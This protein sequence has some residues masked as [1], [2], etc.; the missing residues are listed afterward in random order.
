MGPEV[1]IAAVS[2]VVAL[3]SV[4][5]TYRTALV[6]HRL[7]DEARNREKVEL[8][9]DLFRRYRVPLLS[10]AESL[11]SRLH[12]VLS[13]D[14]LHAYLHDGDAEDRYYVRHN[15]VY[16][17]AEHLAWLE[18]LRRE[19]RF[20]DL[21]SVKSTKELFAAI[22]R[23]HHPLATDGLP[24][25]FRVFRGHQRAIGEVMLHRVETSDGT[26]TDV[27]GYAAFCHRLET[28][29][30]FA[31]WFNRLL[32]EVDDVEAGGRRGNERLVLLQN[33]LVALI[34]LLDPRGEW[35]PLEHRE[36][37]PRADVTVPA[38]RTPN[39]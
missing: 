30:G 22:Q 2:A 23:I 32:A 24:G 10:S 25:P 34:E 35:L 39:G 9:E 36:R 21:D 17:L 12:N 5:V 38:S 1:V 31:S 18:V 4:A 11:Q 13:R 16:V 26:V 20:L 33:E 28:D 6:T 14:F 27:L 3:I 8:A 19:Q 7:Q 29:P 15:T 37:L